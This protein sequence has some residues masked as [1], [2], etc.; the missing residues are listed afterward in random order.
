LLQKGYIKVLSL[1]EYK[2]RVG[3]PFSKSINNNGY[4]EADF[5]FNLLDTWVK[6]DRTAIWIGNKSIPYG[7][8]PRIDPV[9]NFSTNLIK[10][11]IGFAQ[12]FGVFV[13]TPVSENLDIELSVTSGGTMQKPILVCDNL[14]AET[15]SQTVTPRFA[16]SDYNYDNTWLITG[17]LGSPTYK[18]NEVG[19]IGVSGKINNTLVANDLSLINRIGGDWIFKYYEKLKVSNQVV[20]GHNYSEK[21][22]SFAT[23]NAQ[24]GVDVYLVNKFFITGSIAINYYKSRDRNFYRMNYTSANSLTYVFSPHTRLRINHYYARVV[25][26][27]ERQAGLLL[28]FVTGIGKR[29]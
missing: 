16:F 24:S 1:V 15:A 14:I 25:E 29:N 13:K 21:E 17:R 27:D 9:S 18:K 20:F 22:G 11:D 7:H 3:I 2:I 26:A 23:V 10:M 6:W 5:K 4:P 8:N 28:Q 12:D 19:L